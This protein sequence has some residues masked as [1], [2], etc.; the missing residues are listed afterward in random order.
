MPLV[1]FFVM[2]LVGVALGVEVLLDIHLLIYRA[3][4]YSLINIQPNLFIS[5]GV[6]S[7]T[8]SS[9]YF[10]RFFMHAARFWLSFCISENLLGISQKFYDA[11]SGNLSTAYSLH[12]SHFAWLDLEQSH[13]SHLQAWSRGRNQQTYHSSQL[14]I[15]HSRI[16]HNSQRL[17][18]PSI[19]RFWLMQM[20]S[21]CEQGMP[22]FLE[23]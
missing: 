9:H 22:Y 13:I 14:I 8:A 7:Y 2:L 21:S 1:V 4:W 16:N 23:I 5:G 18:C 12:S 15:N 10:L 6:A 11:P 17:S 20:K 19:F 3:N